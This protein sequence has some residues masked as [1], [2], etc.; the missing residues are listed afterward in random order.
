MRE[1]FV[2]PVVETEELDMGLEGRED[3]AA[4]HDLLLRGVPQKHP[5]RA[6]EKT[7]G[8]GLDCAPLLLL[9]APAPADREL[10]P[11]CVV[12]P[13]EAGVGSPLALDGGPA[14]RRG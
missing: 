6:A 12:A 14:A 10:A 1:T 11:P 7:S 2:C 5:G 8:G 3:K 9:Q 4:C 13:P